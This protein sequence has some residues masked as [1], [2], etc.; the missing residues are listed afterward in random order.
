MAHQTSLRKEELRIE[1]MDEKT[2]EKL[3][4]LGHENGSTGMSHDGKLLIGVD[5][6]MMTYPEID[7]LLDDHLKKN[8]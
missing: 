3:K 8:G 5:G 6:R 7:K 4:Q 1:P 2:L